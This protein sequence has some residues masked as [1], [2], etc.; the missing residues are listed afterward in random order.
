MS[1]V[2]CR[3]WVLKKH[4]YGYPEREDLDLLEEELP[5]L[6]EGGIGQISSCLLYS[7]VCWLS[8][9]RLCLVGGTMCAVLVHVL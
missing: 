7:S 5:I 4:F 2:K 1:G 6:K 3:K 8:H 9:R